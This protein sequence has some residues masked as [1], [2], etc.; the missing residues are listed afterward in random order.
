MNV[1]DC[2]FCKFVRGEIAPKKVHEDTH[3][4]AFHDINPQAPTHVLVIP[5]EHVA[6][7]DELEAKHADL[8][9]KL[10]VG[11]AETARVLGLKSYR[12]IVNTGKEAGQTVFH[13]H[14]HVLSGRH[15]TWPPG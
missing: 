3:V 11:V 1:K 2:L 12:C 15:F 14:V 9:G 8:G 13:L 6:S 5:K 7:L 4:L 10:L